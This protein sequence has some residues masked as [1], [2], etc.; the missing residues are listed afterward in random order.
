MR[1]RDF[2]WLITVPKTLSIWLM[3]RG[4]AVESVSLNLREG[5][6]ASVWTTLFEC[7][8][9]DSFRERLMSYFQRACQGDLFQK[10]RVGRGKW[11]GWVHSVFSPLGLVKTIIAEEHEWYLTTQK[12]LPQCNLSKCQGVLCWFLVLLC[13]CLSVKRFVHPKMGGGE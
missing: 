10:S 6:S 3:R 2:V 11:L 13:N 12:S 1:E 4:W 5:N 7:L 8:A 9:G